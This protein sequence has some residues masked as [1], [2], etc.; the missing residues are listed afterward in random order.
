MLKKYKLI[1]EYDGS[2]K[3]GT[4]VIKANSYPHYNFNGGNLMTAI[5]QYFVENTPEFWELVKEKEWEIVSESKW[6]KSNLYFIGGITGSHKT[7]NSV[8]RLS[9]EIIFS[10]GDKV[11]NPKLKSNA[12]FT[13][14][15]FELDFEGEHMLAL[16]GNGAVGIH[17]IE[18]YKE[19][20]LITEDGVEL[21]EDDEYFNVFTVKTEPS[22]ELFSVGGPYKAKPPYED[23]LCTIKPGDSCKY[24]STYKAAGDWIDLNKLQYSNSDLYKHAER[25]GWVKS[26][27]DSLIYSIKKY[28]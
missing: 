24:F 9:D 8:K 15:R 12:S 1:K 13:I 2:P 17:K 14:T 3:L 6:V 5:T 20:I 23:S 18:K 11:I 4:I 19:P 28:K 7:I 21:F 22:F 26:A 27:V 25:L 16:G 10:I